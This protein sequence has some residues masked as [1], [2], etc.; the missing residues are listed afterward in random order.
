MVR[1]ELVPDGR[2]EASGAAYGLA[3]GFVNV[4][5]IITGGGGGGP[6]VS[7]IDV[8]IVGRQEMWNAY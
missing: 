5:H 1:G 2:D 6:K 8:V 7:V 4:V 3:G